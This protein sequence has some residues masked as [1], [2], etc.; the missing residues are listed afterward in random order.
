M[1]FWINTSIPVTLYSNRL[2]FR[3]SNNSFNLDADLLKTMTNYSFNVGHSNAQDQNMIYEF[4]KEMKF[5]IKQV[6]GKSPRDEF[7]IKLRNSPAIM[8]S[9]ISTI[10]SSSDPDDLCNGLILLLQGKKAGNDFYV[11]IEEIVALVN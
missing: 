11:I 1:I 10:F 9:D 3:D 2:T 8:A 6:G 7:F 4:G 5:S